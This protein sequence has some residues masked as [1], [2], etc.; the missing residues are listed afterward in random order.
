MRSIYSLAKR[1]AQRRTMNSKGQVIDTATTVAVSFF[2]FILIVFVILYGISAL[3]PGSFFTA[4]SSEQ[5]ATNTL[6]SNFTTGIANF[7]QQIPPAMTI[8]GV[9][10]ILGF[11]G[12]L[13]FIVLRFRN[14]GVGGGG[15]AL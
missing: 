5:N 9:V 11:L 14:Q 1:E 15:G 4:G 6:R 7:S 3:N 8:L 2:V 13:V 12:L 10:L